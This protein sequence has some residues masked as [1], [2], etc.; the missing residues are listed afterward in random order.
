MQPLDEEHQQH[1]RQRRLVWL[2]LGAAVVLGTASQILWKWAASESSPSG[3]AL[4]VLCQ[5]MTN[6][7]FALAIALYILQFFNWMA[8]LKHAD[9]S[10]AQPITAASY[11]TV[12]ITAWAIWPAEEALP[13]HRLMGIG[14]IL[15][16]VYFITRT[17]HKSSREAMPLQLAGKDRSQ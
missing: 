1:L 5:I 16:G 6:W 7:K 11:V 3:S 8:V 9:L 14:L 15:L 2:G 17:P 4:Q 12:G 13:P 10:Y